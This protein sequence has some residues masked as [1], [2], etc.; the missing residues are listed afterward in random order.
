MLLCIVLRGFVHTS[1]AGV[2]LH[3][4]IWV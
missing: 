3:V 4:V 2:N 1:V